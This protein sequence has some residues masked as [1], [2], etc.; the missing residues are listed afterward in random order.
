[1][2]AVLWA[3]YI[4]PQYPEVYHAPLVGEHEGVAVL[5]IHIVIVVRGLY[6]H[7]LMVGGLTDEQGLHRFCHKGTRIDGKP[8][9]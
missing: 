9:K 8:G 3:W 4:C 5:D 7:L 1:V 2:A 6:C